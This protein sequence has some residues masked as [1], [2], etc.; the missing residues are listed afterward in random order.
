MQG[1]KIIQ[2][3]GN[4]KGLENIQILVAPILTPLL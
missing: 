4:Q 1:I 2:L 3:V